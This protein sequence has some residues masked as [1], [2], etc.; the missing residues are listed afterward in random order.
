[1]TKRWFIYDPAGPALCWYD[2]KDEMIAAAKNFMHE[3]HCDDFWSEE[4][5]NVVGGHGELPEMPG[6]REDFSDFEEAVE[7]LQTHEAFETVI[8]R[9]DNYPDGE[10]WPYDGDVDYIAEFGLREIKK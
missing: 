2:T 4:V 6:W 5:W 8:D 1:M 7:R 3:N 10:D 9:I